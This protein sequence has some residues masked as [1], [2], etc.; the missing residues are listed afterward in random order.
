MVP[1]HSVPKSRLLIFFFFHLR[2]VPKNVGFNYNK[3]DYLLFFI[4]NTQ[5]V[6]SF[7]DFFSFLNFFDLFSKGPTPKNDKRQPKKI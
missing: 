1:R 5:M 2:S 3:L 6:L 4:S 7:F